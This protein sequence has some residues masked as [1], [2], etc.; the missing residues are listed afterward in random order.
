MKKVDLIFAIV[1]VFTASVFVAGE[2][3][4]DA[5]FLEIEKT[6]TLH[7]DGSTRFDYRHKVQL[8]T[9]YA[10]NRYLGETFIVYNPEFQK[11]TIEKSETTMA[12]GKKVA[13]PPNAFN[14][15]LPGGAADAAAYAHLREMVLTHT[16]LERGCTVELQYRI[17]T[18]AEFLPGLMGEEMAGDPSPIQKWTVTVQIPKNRQLKYRFLNASREPETE[19]RADWTRFVWTR[20]NLPPLIAE[21]NHAPFS[22]FTP[23]LVF[24][25]CTDWNPVNRF[26]AKTFDEKIRLPDTIKKALLT[27]T[28]SSDSLSTLLRIRKAVAEQ[29]GDADVN[30][31]W[32]GFRFLSAESTFRYNRGTILDKT[33][34]LHSLLKSSGYDSQPVL[35][36]KSRAC[37]GEIPSLFQFNGA[38]VIVRNKTGNPWILIPKGNQNRPGH[39]EL[40]GKCLFPFGGVTSECIR[41]PG[42]KPESNVVS[43]KADL[44]V[45]PRLEVHGTV[46]LETGGYLHDG[47]ALTDEKSRNEFVKEKIAT[48]LEN[49]V[50]ETIEV[51]SLDPDGGIFTASIH[52][53]D[54]FHP[55]PKTRLYKF[56]GLKNTLKSWNIVPS[57]NRRV[58][59]LQLPSPL[60]E[61]LE[62]TWTI[63]DS[64]ALA[65]MQN[66]LSATASC[67]SLR[68]DWRVEGQALTMVREWAL[69]QT[70]IPP[71]GYR[72]FR[73]MVAD[74]E[75]KS[76]GGFILEK[77]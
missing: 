10:V 48:V 23:C 24:S 25:T 41:L 46:E 21:P 2:I 62:L 29:I 50:V 36:S 37:D 7:P 76:S 12:D 20:K 66:P 19:S 6:Y 34:L 61:R 53:K 28:D 5:V 31:P 13:S 57:Q 38:C 68:M 43:M 75:S 72:E 56:A 39:I 52:G 8:L 60:K 54:W 40:A 74:V 67:G 30:F 59:P 3:A 1:S 17:D 45:D 63:P 49:V 9:Y 27:D 33:I 35:I 22:E 58:T 15:V 73:A 32:I 42:S 65:S 44:R 47:L 4:S 26:L 69:G 55:I 70:V 14:E 77:K 64:F 16:G 71:S 11:L 51:K 18:Q